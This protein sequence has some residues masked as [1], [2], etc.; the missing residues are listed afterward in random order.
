MLRL[1]SGMSLF[2][3]PEFDPTNVGG[4]Y[5]LN[6]NREVCEERD[7]RK[8]GEWL[9][10]NKFTPGRVG[11]TVLDEAMPLYVSTISLGLEHDFGRM[12]LN[13]MPGEPHLPQH[14]FETM[15]FAGGWRMLCCDF[16]ISG[17]RPSRF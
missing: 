4:Y 1:V 8:W 14:V 3:F 5:V 10:A 6:A 9:E 16:E 12:L 17:G 11:Y 13:L 7:L 2:D 15:I